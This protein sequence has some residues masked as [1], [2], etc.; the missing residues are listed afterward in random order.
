MMSRAVPSPQGTGTGSVSA[1]SSARTLLDSRPAIVR[2]SPAGRNGLLLF[3][4]F[5]RART[6]APSRQG[7]RNRN[8]ENVTDMDSPNGDGGPPDQDVDRTDPIWPGGGC[9]L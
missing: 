7:S 2:I 3:M 1:S 5:P 8:L 9:I 4:E 6:Q